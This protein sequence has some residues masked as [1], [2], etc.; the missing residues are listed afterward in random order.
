MFEVIWKQE[1]PA[2]L[3][4]ELPTRLTYSMHP[5]LG[6]ASLQTLFLY[7]LDPRLFF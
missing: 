6:V 5:R 3:I 1:L 2:V 7:F 4:Y